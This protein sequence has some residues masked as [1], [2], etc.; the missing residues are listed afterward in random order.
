VVNV[1]VEQIHATFSQLQQKRN[2]LA[3]REIAVFFKVGLEVAR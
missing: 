1:L 2:G 3:L